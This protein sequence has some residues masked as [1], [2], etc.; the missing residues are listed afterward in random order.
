MGC[1]SCSFCLVEGTDG[2]VSD[3][4]SNEVNDASS[5][6]VYGLQRSSCPNSVDP[7]SRPKG[8]AFKSTSASLLHSLP[9]SNR[10]MLRDNIE[11]SVPLRCRSMVIV[12]TS[13]PR[14]TGGGRRI[15]ANN[16]F[17]QAPGAFGL[18]VVATQFSSCTQDARSCPRGNFVSSRSTV[19]SMSLQCGL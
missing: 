14:I 2:E 5:L 4:G 1:C 9:V 19:V 11:R 7:E 15:L 16:T 10:W 8:A 12:L 3:H 17:A 13:R 6:F 18:L